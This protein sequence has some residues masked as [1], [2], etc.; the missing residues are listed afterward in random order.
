MAADRPVPERLLVVDDNVDAADSLA[1]VLALGGADVR[2][3]YNGPDALRVFDDEVISVAFIDLGMPGMH[4]VE[5]ARQL[6]ARDVSGLVTL[7]AL[8]GSGE[9]EDIAEALQAGF[10]HHVLKPAGV[11]ELLAA[12]RRSR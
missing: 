8:T 5:V 11:D 12:M 1:L 2:V 6:R 9:P 3:A 10:D 7:V 4:G